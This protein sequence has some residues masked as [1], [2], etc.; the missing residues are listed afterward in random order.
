MRMVP[1]GAETFHT[2]GFRVVGTARTFPIRVANRFDEQG[3]QVGYSGPCYDDQV[4]ITFE[5]IG[6]KTEL[7]TVTK[8][9][10]RIFTFSGQQIEEAIQYNGADGVFLNFVNYCRDEAELR[11]VVDAIH[12][13][14]AAVRWI[15]LGPCYNDVFEIKGAGTNPRMEKIV[16]LWRAYAAGRINSAQ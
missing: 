5:D 3:Q 2:D 6:Q 1:D 15:G 11:A 14:G 12:A 8:L 9:P 4:E 10:R 16:E 7:T 13:T